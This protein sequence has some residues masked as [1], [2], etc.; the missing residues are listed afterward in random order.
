MRTKEKRPEIGV[1]RS[2]LSSVLFRRL[3]KSPRKTA[4]KPRITENPLISHDLTGPSHC[5]PPLPMISH[6]LPSDGVDRPLPGCGRR[7]C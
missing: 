1:E 4:K 3:T 6:E 2:A 5:V 7:G